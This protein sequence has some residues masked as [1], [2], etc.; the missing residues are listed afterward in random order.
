ME[1]LQ[2]RGCPPWQLRSELPAWG[3][4]PALVPGD[5]LSDLQRAGKIGDP[6]YEKNFK[7]QAWLSFNN[8]W[9]YVLHFTAGFFAGQP[10]LLIFE[11]IKMGAEVRLNGKVLGLAQDQ[12]L[13]YTFSLAASDLLP[14]EDQNEL[15]VRFPGRSA[16]ETNGRFMA[17]TGG[18][19][20]APY[21]EPLEPS[22]GARTFTR[23]IWA[24]VKLLLANPVTVTYVVPQV[25]FLG[26]YPTSRLEDGNHAG[27]E[28]RM[29][30]H[31]WASMA[32][33]VVIQGLTD[34]GAAAAPSWH[35]VSAGTSTVELRLLASATDIRLWW[36]AGLGEQPLYNVYI[37][38]HPYGHRPGNN[39]IPPL[40]V[41]S[42]IGFRHFALVT[43]NDTDPAFVRESASAEGSSNLG[44][45]FRVNGVAFLSRGANVIPMEELEGRL[46]DSAHVQM[47]RSSQLAGMNTLRVW[48]GGIYLPEAFYSACD[49][50]GILLY[51]DMQYAQEGHAAAVTRAQEAE[52]RHQVRRLAQHTS[53][54]LWDGCNECI[55][56]MGTPTEVYALF[57]M[58][59]IAE[60]DAS[61]AI[62]PS[63]PA[64]GWSTGVHRLTSLP[65]PAKHRL[66][67]TPNST[68]HALEWHGPYQHGT[69]FP[70]VNGLSKLDTVIANI[71]TRLKKTDVGVALGPAHR[72]SFASE[73]GCVVMSS[74][75]SMSPTLAPHHWGLHGGSEPD[76]CI[77]EF[78]NNCTGHNVMAER[79]YPCDNLIMAYFG[80]Q[81]F[82][83]VGEH[84]FK[85]QLYQCMI[86]QALHMKGDIEAR[87]AKNQ[88]GLL[89][90]QLNEIWPTGG[91]GSLEYGTNV[92]GQ[93][94]GG[95]WKP[96]HYWYKA[97]LFADVIAVCGSGGRCFVRN[98]GAAAFRGQ[99]QVVR[100]SLQSGAIT[101]LIQKSLELAAGPGTIEW[102]RISTLHSDLAVKQEVVRLRLCDGGGAVSSETVATF[103]TPKDLEVA[104]A[105]IR[106]E[107]ARLPN[108]DG[109]I[110]VRLTSAVPAMYVVLTTLAQG[111]FS[112]NAFLLAGVDDDADSA[113]S[114]AEHDHHY[115][116][117]KGIQR[118]IKF[119]PIGPLNMSLF[120]SSLRVEDLSMYTTNKETSNDDSTL[121]LHFAAG[122]Q[123]GVVV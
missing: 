3:S 82:E 88:L 83:S 28:V 117:S 47:V 20:W 52:L 91:W 41:Q 87:R 32:A 23:G 100:V 89:V 39:S 93:V 45:Y 76:H 92:P 97:A 9:E 55:V 46:S 119:F 90:W 123:E 1:E 99:L 51:H 29:H 16:I 72:N 115:A 12:F 101:K 6:L 30:I 75:E 69:G 102:F 121:P 108:T 70:A 5:L 114:S 8:T 60:E 109:S 58:A 80:A 33:S 73:F 85:R 56:K 43:G 19:D 17:C 67:T 11:G 44:M 112:D 2:A 27:F 79:N 48:G 71:P 35:N 40:Q 98:D 18:W 94:L 110:D 106:L 107:I 25:Q 118:V 14:G 38:L 65:V 120:Q 42:R 15:V 61:R 74:F 95:R 62:W 113:C 57:V 84:A 116:D 59:V 68:E 24:E 4:I 21:T 66:L 86:A 22:S 103:V 26:N 10:S 122:R 36:P 81:D 63:C 105:K 77:G 78:A 53:I 31:I 96:L 111:R 7:E 37:N 49:E 34:W 50:L 54:A 104:Q 13:R 64:Y